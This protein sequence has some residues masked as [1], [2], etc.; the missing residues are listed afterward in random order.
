LQWKGKIRQ[1]KIKPSA[2][3]ERNLMF[4]DKIKGEIVDQEMEKAK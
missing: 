3:T 1:W 4:Y 2:E